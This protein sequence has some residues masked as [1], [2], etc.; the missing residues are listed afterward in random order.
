MSWLQRPVTT[1]FIDRM[2]HAA[3]FGASDL[4][5]LATLGVE[6]RVVESNATIVPEGPRNGTIHVLLEG[7]AARVKILENGSRQIPALMLP[8]DICD[9]GAL[10]LDR[11]DWAVSALTRCTVAAIPRDGLNAL[12][13]R[14]KGLRAAIGRMAAVENSISTQWTVCLGRRS[15]RERLA[16][17]L[18]EL[19]VRLQAVRGASADGFLLPLTQEEIADVLGLTAVHVNRTLQ[20]LRSDGL[21]TL[22][23]YR[24]YIPDLGALRRLAGFDG[25]YLHSTGDADKMVGGDGGAAGGARRVHAP[26]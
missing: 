16:H 8:G 3:D 19:F 21:I 22:K 10:H 12:L 9:I 17:L 13:D 23:E 4:S 20:N 1:S 25:N 11:L 14:H 24:L 15:A 5:A 6:L 7:W 2:R 18:C 26:A